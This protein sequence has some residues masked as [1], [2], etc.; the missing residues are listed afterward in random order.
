VVVNGAYKMKDAE[1]TTEIW[2]QRQEWKGIER[3]RSWDK[4]SLSE[5]KAGIGGGMRFRE[6]KAVGRRKRE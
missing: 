3:G 4:R 2:R 5:A 1:S 6:A